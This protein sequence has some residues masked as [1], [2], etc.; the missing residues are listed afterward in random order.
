MTLAMVPTSEDAPTVFDL[1]TARD[2]I[3]SV[4]WKFA[5]TMPDWPHEYTVKGWRPELHSDFEA[6][7]RP[8]KAQECGGAVA[9]RTC[10]ADHHNHYL[11]IGEWK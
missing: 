3:D 9:A 8:I 1:D 10:A 5:S 11:V 6:F 4:R 7:C 2:Y